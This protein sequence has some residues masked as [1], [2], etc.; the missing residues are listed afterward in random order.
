M[1]V[2][3]LSR[4]Y[5]SVQGLDQVSGVLWLLCATV[6]KGLEALGG[7]AYCGKRTRSTV[8]RTIILNI[9]P[10]IYFGVLMCLHGINDRLID[11]F[12]RCFHQNMGFTVWVEERLNV[13][14]VSCLKH[15]HSNQTIKHDFNLPL[16]TSNGIC[17]QG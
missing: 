14:L 2:R 11:F 6:S 7:C 1:L 12:I 16:H 17:L 8:N 3:H 15:P 9:V 4:E 5:R 10:T 13:H